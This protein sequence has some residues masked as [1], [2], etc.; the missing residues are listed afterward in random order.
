MD[1][2][3]LIEDLRIANKDASE[4]M[5][6]M[7]DGG[8]ANLDSVFLQLPRAREIKV[9]EAIKEA[10]LH[11]RAKVKWNW[12]GYGYMITPTGVGQGN[13]RTKAV[14]VMRNELKDLGWDVTIFSQMD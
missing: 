9:L 7:N 6:G 13:T 4:A 1:Y 10:G 8:T 11:C 5:K 14:D 3:K 2:N 12:I